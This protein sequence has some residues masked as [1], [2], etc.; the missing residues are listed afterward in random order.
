M[1]I[2][3]CCVKQDPEE[4]RNLQKQLPKIEYEANENRNKIENGAYF[5]EKTTDKINEINTNVFNNKF[6]KGEE[7]LLKEEKIKKI[8]KKF[9]NFNNKNKF[10]NEI[11][12]KM[13]EETQSFINE[14]YEECSKGGELPSCGDFNLEGWKKYYPPNER[15]FLYQKGKVFPNQIR[16]KNL[17]NKNNLEIYEGEV[18]IDNL[19]HGFGILTTPQ[20]EMR[21]SWRKDEF[22]GWGRKL[23]RNGEIMEAKFVNGKLNGKGYYK[24][25]TCFYEGEFF[26][27]KKCGKGILKTQKYIYK[28]DFDNDEF[29]GNGTIEFLEEG[30][31]YTGN[32][33][34]NEIS[35]KG[36]FEWKNG[37][38]YE[39]DMK[40][41]KMDGFG[42]FTFN[43]G[44]I[45]E[46][47]YKNGIKQGKGKLI[48]PGDK[49]YEGYFDKGLPD[50]EGIYIE[51][52]KVSKV[53]FSQGKFI[54]YIEE[55]KNN[56]ENTL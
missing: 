48:Y 22:T 31:K 10:E 36:I 3:A 4:E 38:I 12:P 40:K 39:G 41:G 26:D 2:R 50:G 32:F 15:F 27:S 44:K 9:R 45:Y 19:K 33:L 51:N 42:K 47:E 6:F 5:T 34:K 28:G 18:N 56:P 23:M 13:R 29:N 30:S 46:G 1:G 37:D 14:L 25:L 7:D 21:G 55:G 53:L 54:Q 11:K 24:N 20:Y 35:G 17:N 43:D 49:I 52:G 8:Q 16:I